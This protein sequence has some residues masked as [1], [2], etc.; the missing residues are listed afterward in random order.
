MLAFQNPTSQ[1]RSSP[2]FKLRT[3]NTPRMR[4][5]S[6]KKSARVNRGQLL[7]RRKI[8]GKPGLL[9]SLSVY[10]LINFRSVFRLRAC[11]PDSRIRWVCCNKIRSMASL[12]R[13]TIGS[14]KC[15][16]AHIHIQPIYWIFNEIFQFV[17]FFEMEQK[18]G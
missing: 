8:S 6:R 13:G 9:S 7:A 4:V 14:W 3:S 10:R 16:I 1:G 12:T 18:Y 15:G 2:C 11:F 5:M 17:I